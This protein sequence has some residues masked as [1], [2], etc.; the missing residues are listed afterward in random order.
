MTEFYLPS[1]SL[2]PFRRTGGT[3]NSEIL[4]FTPELPGSPFRNSELGNS[5]F[6]LSLAPSFP[7]GGGNRK[8]EHGNSSKLY[9]Q[10]FQKGSR[11]QEPGNSSVGNSPFYLFFR[12]A[13]RR[14]SEHGMSLAYLP[15]EISFENVFVR[16]AD[17]NGLMC[18]PELGTRNT[19]H[20]N[21]SVHIFR[22]RK[23]E[24][25]GTRKME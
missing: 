16:P 23:I 6:Y 20:G 10:S 11:N 21:S 3:R 12:R 14:K 1:T 9:L 24:A 5:P 2:I 22:I 4:I 18:R 17:Q 19:E 7:R 15:R 8:M 13:P 25:T